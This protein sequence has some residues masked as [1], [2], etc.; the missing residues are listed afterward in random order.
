MSLRAS[1]ESS[2]TRT[3]ILRAFTMATSSGHP[4]VGRGLNIR[5]GVPQAHE[6]LGMAGEEVA[7]RIQA[8][9]QTVYDSF[10][11]GAAEIEHHVAAEDNV[12]GAEIRG[13]VQKVESFEADGAADGF[14]DAHPSGPLSRTGLKEFRQ[15]WW[16]QVAQPIELIDAGLSGCQRPC[17]DVRCQNL[18]CRDQFVAAL[19]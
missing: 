2:T 5:Q 3:R 17:R 19:I 1:G 13:V 14:P 10:L 15:P 18:E 8:L 6:A 9:R 7:S 4:L 12:K 11:G 16:R